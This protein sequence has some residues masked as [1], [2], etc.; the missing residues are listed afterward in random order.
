MKALVLAAG[1]GKRMLPLTENKPKPMLAIA[2]KPMIQRSLEALRDNGITDVTII[3]GW[4]SK[5]IRT[6]LGSGSDLGMN[7]QYLMQEK[8][9]GTA[10][11]IGTGEPNM[12]GEE[13]ISINGD[14]L[15]TPNMVKAVLDRYNETGKTIMSLAEVPDPCGFG[16]IETRDGM[17]DKIWEKP[18]CPPTNT[19]NAGIYCF[20]PGIFDRIRQTP[21]SP[22]G[23]YEITDTLREL[24]ADEGVASLLLPDKWLDIG[25]PWDLLEANKY[26]MENLETSIEGEVEDGVTI[27][28]P[29]VIKKG[30]YIKAGTYIEGPVIIDEKA[31]VGP[32]S[33]LRPSTYIGKGCHI[34]AATEIKNSIIMDNS[35]APHHNYVG[36]SIMGEGCNLGSGTKV[37]NLRFD[38]GNVPTVLKGKLVDSGRRKLGIIMGDNV[39][40][41]LNVCLDPGTVVGGG[42]RI[43]PGAYVRGYL[44]PGS[45]VK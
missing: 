18:E 4:E 1:E 39:K 45:F 43:A 8:R 20:K 11:A 31:R 10:H 28:G 40:T 21:L 32:N 22:R 24:V 36:D 37:A 13:F 27:R 29:V 35:N 42:V 9:M 2:G 16:V 23:E 3:I 41:G 19:V 6:F 17:V 34:G 5:K 15:L 26:H 25:R 30:A 33:Y 44:A 12:G 14:V 7:I 38:D